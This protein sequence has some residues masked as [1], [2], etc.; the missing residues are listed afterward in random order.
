MATIYCVGQRVLLWQL[1]CDG[2]IPPDRVVVLQEIPVIIT[3]IKTGVLGMATKEPYPEQSLRAV[4]NNGRIYEKS[5]NEWFEFY[6][7]H[8]MFGWFNRW[9]MRDDGVVLE[10]HG[11]QF[12]TPREAT[13]A[14]ESLCACDRFWSR[15]KIPAVTI[16]D[17]MGNPIAPPELSV[18]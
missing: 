15:F 9:E 1:N 16:V 8:G 7:G 18:A 10:Q 4:D 3:E 6:G 2:D 12:W 13:L 11:S 14:Y 5:W 17:V